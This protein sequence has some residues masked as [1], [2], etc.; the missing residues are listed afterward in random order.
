LPLKY[1]EAEPPVNRVR[2]AVAISPAKRAAARKK[3]AAP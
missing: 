3:L 1:Q 2:R